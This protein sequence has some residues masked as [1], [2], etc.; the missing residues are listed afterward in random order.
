MKKA[1]MSIVVGSKTVLVACGIVSFVI[2]SGA[3]GY[4]V[5]S[6][7]SSG[8]EE[9]TRAYLDEL[10][11]QRFEMHGSDYTNPRYGPGRLGKPIDKID[12]TRDYDFALLNETVNKLDGIDRKTVLRKIFSMAT[13]GAVSETEKHRKLLKF[14]QKASFHNSWMQPMYPDGSTTYDPLVLLELGEMRCGHVARIAVDIYSAQGYQ[15]R[16]VQVGAHQLA[17]VFYDGEW[18]YFDV[19]PFGGGNAIVKDDGTIPSMRE[20]STTPA[21]IDRLPHNFEL[22]HEGRT[23]TGSTPYISFYYFSSRAFKH[24][25]PGADKRIQYYEKTAT[26]KQEKGSRDGWNYYKTIDYSQIVLADFE[27]WHQPGAVRFKDI[28]V[29][30]GKITVDWLPSEDRDGDLIGY[31][32][33]VATRTRGWN[34]AVFSGPQHLQKYFEGGWKPGMYDN[35]FEVPPSDAGFYETSGTSVTIDASDGRNRY[36]TVMPY[37]RH[38]EEFGRVLYFMSEEIVVGNRKTEAANS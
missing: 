16:I 17:E 8:T 2:I 15:G 18:H 5:L 28:R 32:V 12:R 30:D 20:L 25:P 33:F 3:F 19:D 11:L 4:R 35:L 26:A 23:H 9:K 21:N 6:I 37:D 10:S 36:I 22:G 38:G 7:H 24:F 34:H 29:V 13:M 1:H 14:L 31:R 27:P